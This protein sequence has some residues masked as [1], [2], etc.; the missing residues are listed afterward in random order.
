MSAEPLITT[1]VPTYQRPILLKRAIESVLG[2]SYPHFEL[3]VYDNASGDGTHDLVAGFAEYDSRVKYHCRAK[4]IGPIANFALA[5]AAVRTPY[6]N[7]LS[8]DDLLAPNFFR[9]GMQT[10]ARYPEAMLFSGATIKAA[11]NGKVFDVPIGRFGAGLYSPPQGLFALL[12]NGHTDWTGVIFRSEVL[13]TVGGLDIR[14]GTAVDMDFEWRIASKCPIVVSKEPVAI[15]IVHP[16]QQ[17]AAATDYH[18]IASLW[19]SWSAA[20]SNIQNVTSLNKADANRST[21]MILRRIR[22]SIFLHGCDAAARGMFPAARLAANILAHELERPHT[23]LILRAFASVTSA[24]PAAWSEKFAAAMRGRH[25][26]RFAN[27][28]SQMSKGIYEEFVHKVL[29]Q[30]QSHRPRPFDAHA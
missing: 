15:F 25:L 1:V 20:L 8:D 9:L 24:T 18:R 22:R 30:R 11:P 4:N 5:V 21:A 7:L 12:R 17:S 19:A 26:A 28:G 29:S 10:F 16:S 13:S 3:H 23:A 14:T 27:D 6:F 2:Q